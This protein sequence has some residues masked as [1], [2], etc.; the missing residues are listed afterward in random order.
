M[1]ELTDYAA[2]TL[3]IVVAALGVALAGR[4]PEYR[5]VAAF[6]VLIAGLDIFRVYALRPIY[7][8]EPRPY[9]GVPRVGFHAGQAIFFAWPAGIAA[10][11]LDTAGA[12]PRTRRCQAGRGAVDAP[13]E[14]AGNHGG[15]IS[16]PLLG[17]AR[18]F[19]PLVHTCPASATALWRMK[20]IGGELRVLR[21]LRELE[22][23][24]GVL[25]HRAPRLPKPRSVG[26]SRMRKAARRPDASL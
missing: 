11:G 7:L 10:L 8:P 21:A 23:R 13:G 25:A 3:R 15:M 14:L 26:A 1:H 17:C 19:A 16:E 24:H 6:L 2:F 20:G 12:F 9:T 22:Q 4:R 5:P 18:P